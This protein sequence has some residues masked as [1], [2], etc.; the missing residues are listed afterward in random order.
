LRRISLARFSTRFSRSNSLSRSRSEV[1][2]PRRAGLGLAQPA[3]PI[4][5]ASQPCAL[6]LRCNRA[7]RGPL[8]IVL[9]HVLEY[10][11][12]RPFPDFRR[13][14]LRCTHRL[15]PLKDWSLR[16]SRGGS[17]ASIGERWSCCLQHFTQSR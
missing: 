2:V 12:D 4:C 11:P 16:E 15:H 14:P 3:A 5:A 10:E 17:E 6:N 1:V 9:G 8:R 7:D 13:K